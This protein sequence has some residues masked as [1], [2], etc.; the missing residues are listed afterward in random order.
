VRYLR[1]LV[2][3]R[4]APPAADSVKLSVQAQLAS[5]VFAA[6]GQ[7]PYVLL[8]GASPPKPGALPLATL[9]PDVAKERPGL[10]RATLGA[11]SEVSEAVAQAKT[12]A[13]RALWRPAALWA[14]LLAGVAGL[15][16]MV[17]RLAR[18]GAKPGA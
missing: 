17:W 5:L 2:D 11:W 9:L 15:A 18:G 10:G 13:Q 7:P 14:L 3:A 8:A 4:S 16:L 1:L 12:E 6:Q